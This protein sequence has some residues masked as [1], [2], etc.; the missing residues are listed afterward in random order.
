MKSC[1]ITVSVPSELMSTRVQ[2]TLNG[3]KPDDN[4]LLFSFE[5]SAAV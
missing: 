3:Y 4:R 5:K 2:E 1:I